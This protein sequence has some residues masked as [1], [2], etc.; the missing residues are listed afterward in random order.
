LLARAAGDPKARAV[1]I[2][3]A[4]VQIADVLVD[5]HRNRRLATGF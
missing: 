4:L 5:I 1:Q 2:E 3:D